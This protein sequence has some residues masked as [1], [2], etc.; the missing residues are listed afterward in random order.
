MS[1]V[2]RRSGRHR[3]PNRHWETLVK[4][5][6]FSKDGTFPGSYGDSFAGVAP[7]SKHHTF[8]LTRPAVYLKKYAARLSSLL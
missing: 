8:R 1:V 5:G 3:V 7:P 4:T 2:Q 6:R